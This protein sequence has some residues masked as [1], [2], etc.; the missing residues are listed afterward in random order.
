[1]SNEQLLAS[2]N[3][4]PAQQAIIPSERVIGSSAALRFD[5]DAGTLAYL[6]EPDVFDDGPTKPVGIWSRVGRADRLLSPD[7][8]IRATPSR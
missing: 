6:A 3:D 5:E 7:T 1:M 4:T 8:A 2:W